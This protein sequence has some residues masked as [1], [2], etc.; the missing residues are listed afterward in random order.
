MVNYLKCQNCKEESERF[1]DLIYCEELKQ[2]L[3]DACYEGYNL[4]KKENEANN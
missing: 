1:E 2:F 3:C 4:E